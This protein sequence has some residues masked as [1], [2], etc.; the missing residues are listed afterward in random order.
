LGRRLFWKVYLTLLASLVLVVVLVGLA[1]RVSGDKMWDRWQT[2]RVQIADMI[3]PPAREPRDLIERTV[4]RLAGAA[5]ADVSLYATDGRLI[6]SSGAPIPLPEDREASG[7]HWRDGVFRVVLQDGRTLLARPDPPPPEPGPRILLLV[8]VVAGAVG[9]AAYPVT[10]RLTRR[11]ENLR[12]GVES[13]GQGSLATRVAEGGRD[14]V[15]QVARTFNAAAARVEALVTGQKA[16]LAN[17]SHELRSP[18]ARL[19]LAVEMPRS[20]G[21]D[22]EIAASLAEL[23]GLVEEILLASRL[24]HDAPARADELTDVDLLGLAAE[25]AAAHDAGVSGEPVELR[26]D[27]TL[28][29]RLLRNLISNAVTHGAPPVEVRVSREADQAVI[30]VSDRGPGVPEDE[31]EALF[32]PFYR[33]SGRSES[34]G[35]W[36]LGLSLVRQ[37]AQRHGG[38]ARCEGAPGGGIVFVVELPLRRTGAA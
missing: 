19:R 12:A 24:D 21:N 18:L 15:A 32:E 33:P 6:A 29:R 36:G 9:L 7:R 14:E 23:D 4:R 31:R 8:L 37:I 27:A 38:R 26:G 25:E 3:I 1:W 16:L 20:S 17:A 30:R 2:F 22:R 5:G 11:L 28:L 34:R 10:A 13:W 35:G